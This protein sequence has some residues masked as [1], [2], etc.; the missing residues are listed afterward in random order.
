MFTRAAVDKTE[1]LVLAPLSV[2]PCY[3]RQGIGTALIAEGHKIA[4]G[5]GYS[6]SIVL[7][8]EQYYPRVGY[9][10]A[11]NFG[12]EVPEGIPAENFMA[13]RLQE[14]AK[15]IKGSV[16]YAEEFGM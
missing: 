9:L 13:V 15:V 8:S 5:M 6:Y 1:I 7:G 2:K 11:E 12:I 16:V 3:Q 14:N 10:P 4:K